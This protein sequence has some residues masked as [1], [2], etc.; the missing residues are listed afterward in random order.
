MKVNKTDLD[1]LKITIIYDNYAFDQ[2]L[3][4]D[5]GFACLIE[6]L[7]RTILFDTGGNGAIFMDNLKRLNI[8]PNG[9]DAVFISHGHY[10]HSGGLQRFLEAN[11][12]VSIYLPRSA[13]ASYKAMSGQAGP[14]IIPVDRPE[15]V[16]DRAMSTG[17]MT[18]FIIAEHSLV[19]PTNKGAVLVTGCAH[20]GICDIVVR[21]EELTNQKVFM[22]I[23]GFHLMSETKDGIQKVISRLQTM[24]VR[25]VAPSH[26]TGQEAIQA[27]AEAFG[28]AFIQ[29]GA[30][31]IIRGLELSE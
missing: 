14:T 5:H 4:T 25:H 7:D 22:A 15:K 1:R 12:R 30:G 13:S 28:N 17:E 21:A 18:S 16:S 24:S 26:C 27:F 2:G 31:R 11:P 10:D 6:G 8:D 29:S 20:P 3:R 19:M 23:G 9:V